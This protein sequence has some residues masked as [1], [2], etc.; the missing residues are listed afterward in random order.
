MHVYVCA[1]TIRGLLWQSRTRTSESRCAGTRVQYI[2]ICKAIK[3]RPV[4]GPR[5]I[6]TKKNLGQTAVCMNTEK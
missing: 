1:L 4:I 6:E 2:C 3:C 5:G